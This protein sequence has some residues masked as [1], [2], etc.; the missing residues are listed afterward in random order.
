MERGTLCW[1]L[2]SRRSIGVLVLGAVGM[3]LCLCDDLSAQNSFRRGDVNC[4]GFVS[5]VDGFDLAQFIFNP[6]GNPLP[7]NCRD[8]QDADDDG[9]VVIVDAIFILNFVLLGGPP[10]PAPGALV[11]GPDPTLDP[12]NCLYPAR[13]CDA[14]PA[15]VV[16]KRGDANCDGCVN[17][18]DVFTMRSILFAGG[19]Q[20]CGCRDA[21][22]A[23]GDLQFTA[24]DVVFL[25]QYI[26]AAGAPPPFPGPLTCGATTGGLGCVAYPPSVCASGCPNV[27]PGDCNSDL[28]I[29]ISD[30]LCLI[31][32]LTT[33]NPA[34]LPCGNGSAVHPSNVS[35]MDW[36]GDTNVNLADVIAELSFIFGFG[37]GHV[38]GGSCV[39]IEACPQVCPI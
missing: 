33:G 29:D 24:S 20:P 25:L 39:F 32:F 19:V 21:L 5:V 15:N 37:P 8:A 28:M 23:N 11:C 7:C 17:V 10:P 1:P 12:L 9:V 13:R 27:L 18:L 4:N 3:T 36:N 35:L 26:S 30:P 16:Y 6:G 34:T 38:L 2:R 14:G 31:G 22:D